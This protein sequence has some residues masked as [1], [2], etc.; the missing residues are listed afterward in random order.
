LK[1]INPGRGDSMP[2][3]FTTVGKPLYFAA[4]D[5]VH[6]YE[7]RRP[8]WSR[9]SVRAPAAAVRR[10]GVFDDRTLYFNAK[11]GGHGRQL[12]KLRP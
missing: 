11:S 6:D 10:T 2:S 1:D 4:T 7:L 12:W 9:T 5:G 3:S 8:R